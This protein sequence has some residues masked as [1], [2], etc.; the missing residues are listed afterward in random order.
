MMHGQKTI[1]F[2]NISLKH[3]SVY[4]ELTDVWSYMCI[5]LPENYPSFLLD[6]NTIYFCHGVPEKS[7]NVKFHENPDSG[8]HTEKQTD[9]YT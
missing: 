5:G 7:S 2:S 4:Q 8:K 3:F 1:K 6:F 9:S